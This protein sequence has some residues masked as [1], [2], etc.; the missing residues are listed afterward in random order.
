LPNQ[1]RKRD[2]PIP[3]DMIYMKARVVNHRSNSDYS[4][5]RFIVGCQFIGRIFDETAWGDG[6]DEEECA[7]QA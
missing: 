7:Q 2:S 1:C 6:G 3:G 5:K 4:G